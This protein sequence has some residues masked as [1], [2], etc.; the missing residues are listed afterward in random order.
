MKADTKVRPLTVRD[1]KTNKAWDIYSELSP[2]EKLELAG[3]FE[4]LKSLTQKQTASVNYIEDNMNEFLVSDDSVNKILSLLKAENI[5]LI[6]LD[7]CVKS[8]SETCLPTKLIDIYKRFIYPSAK[9]AHS[10]DADFDR[11]LKWRISR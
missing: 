6:N 10:L 3:K 7:E 1:S 8:L 9:D 2:M 5:D 4:S 11:L